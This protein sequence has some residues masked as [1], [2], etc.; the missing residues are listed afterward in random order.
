MLARFGSKAKAP[1]VVRRLNSRQE[2][3]PSVVM[4]APVM[5]QLS[6]ARFG[7]WGLIA[8]WNIDPP[9]PGPTIFHLRELLTPPALSSA[10]VRERR[11][12]PLRDAYAI[13]NASGA[14]IRMPCV[15]VS[16]N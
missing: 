1:S 14:A 13:A 12:N 9:P 10:N 7:L 6:T 5:S 4:Y 8:G 11:R 15:P 3:P 16:C 2:V